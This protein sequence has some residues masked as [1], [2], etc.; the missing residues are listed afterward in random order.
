MATITAKVTIMTIVPDNS[1]VCC[2]CAVPVG[3][4]RL[5]I[6]WL[7]IPKAAISLGGKRSTSERY[8]KCRGDR[9]GRIG[10]FL[11]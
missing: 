11:Y 10:V 9:E 2:Q 8:L 7:K 4:E 3:G 5:I 1:Y 6:D